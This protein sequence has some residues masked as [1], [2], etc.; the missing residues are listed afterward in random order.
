MERNTLEALACAWDS[1]I[2]LDMDSDDRNDFRKAIHDAQRI[3][4]YRPAADNAFE[5]K[6]RGSES[7]A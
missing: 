2:A 5:E 6:M 4:M 3:V 1:S 7:D